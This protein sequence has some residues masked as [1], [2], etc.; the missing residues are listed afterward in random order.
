M[1]A[2]SRIK[3]DKVE[4]FLSEIRR[5][6]K[7]WWE[8]NRNSPWV[9][10]GIGDA[11]NWKLLP[12]A[13]RETSGSLMPLIAKIASLELP[14]LELPSAIEETP[15]LRQ[16]LEW[17]NAEEEALFRF[18]NVANE[19]GFDVDA[20]YYQPN[21]SPILNGKLRRNNDECFSGAASLAQHH[22]IPT[23]L[24]DWTNSPIVA[25]YFAA[26]FSPPDS[27]NICVW[28]LNTKYLAFQGH[29]DD[30]FKPFRIMIFR[31]QRSSNNFLHSQ[32]GV[33]TTV[34][35]LSSSDSYSEL[36]KYFLLHQKWPALEEI[37]TDMCCELPILIS[38]E[39]SIEHAQELLWVLEKEGITKASLMP[40]LDNVASV[41]KAK[42]NSHYF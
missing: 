24:L 28:S 10:R 32:S 2:L 37:I 29:S 11:D 14:I 27:K 13:W 35:N 39:L 38:H 6:N 12:S 16:Y 8:Q 30:L 3:F 21:R 34:S 20:G 23:R 31:P 9:F 25:A 5:S 33:F 19:L 26:E 17:T 36:E 41:V 22:G 1:P 40:T 18:A 7:K 15:I 42:W 4:D